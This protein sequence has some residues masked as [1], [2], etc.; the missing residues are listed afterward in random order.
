MRDRVREPM[1]G[2]IR[3]QWWRDVLDRRAAR[4]GGGEPGRGGVAR[5]DRALRL[6][7]QPLA[8]LIEAQP[9]TS[10]TTRCRAAALEGYARNTIAAVF[11]LA[12]LICGAPAADEAAEHAGIACAMTACCAHSP[13]MRRGASSS[14]RPSCWGVRRRAEDIFA[15]QAATGCARALLRG[16]G[17]PTC[18]RVRAAAPAAGVAIPALLPAALVPG[19]LAAMERGGTIRSG[20]RWRFR[21]GAVSGFCGGRRGGLRGRCAGDKQKNSVVGL[22]LQRLSLQPLLVEGGVADG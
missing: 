18:H 11:A 20:R 6:P 14:F 22:R 19:Y 8:D 21:S 10:T 16:R 9:S 4:G 5:H 7:P 12:A 2:E 1:A 15:G 13:F 3:L 17:A